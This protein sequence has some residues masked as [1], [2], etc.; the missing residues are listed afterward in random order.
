MYAPV[1]TRF[2]TYAVE[3]TGAAQRYAA[4]LLDLPAVR[5]WVAQVNKLPQ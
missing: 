4:M 5:A 2:R 3:L 1:A